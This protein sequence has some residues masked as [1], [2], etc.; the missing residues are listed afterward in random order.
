[1]ELSLSTRR[2]SGPAGEH[3]VV[4]VHG[5]LDAYSAP[6][7]RGS[8]VD[9]VAAGWHHLL[10][11][12]DDVPLLDATGLGVLLG[13]AGRVAPHGGSLRLVCTRPDLLRVLRAT[14]LTGLLPVC[15]S[16]REA[17]RGVRPAGAAVPGAPAALLAG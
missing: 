1:M 12:V 14:G 11:D 5:P 16:V 9:L 4:T 8:L 7:L 3:T 2:E 6:Q 13:G 15:G 10:V 17:L